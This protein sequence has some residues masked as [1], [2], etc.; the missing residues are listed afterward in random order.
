MRKR[1]L[2]GILVL[3]LAYMPLLSAC[4]SKAQSVTGRWELSVDEEAVFEFK[5]DKRGNITKNGNV[6]NFNYEISENTLVISGETGEILFV[7]N[8]LSV[9]DDTL[10]MLNNHNGSNVLGTRAEP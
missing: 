10:T 4:G 6:Q 8:N 3:L 9:T 2:I 5:P 7:F 1:V